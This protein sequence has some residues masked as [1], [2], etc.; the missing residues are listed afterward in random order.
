VTRPTS[1]AFAVFAF[2][3]GACNP[4]L[5]AP[6]L[7]PPPAQ[8]HDTEQSHLLLFPQSDAESLLGRAAQR[9][10]DGTWTIADARAPGCEIS[11]RHEKASFHTSRQVAAHS[12]TS[13][14]GGYAKVVSIEAK[15]GRKNTASIDIDNTEI[16][17]ADTRGACG[18][19]VV[20]TVFVGHGKRSLDA[21]AEAGGHADVKAGLVNASPT[22][23]SG[24]SQSDAL[25][26]RDDQAYG[27]DVR[28]N[29]KVEPLDIRVSMP[30]VVS[31]GDNVEVRFE[32]DRPAWLVVYYIDANQHADVL[33]P[34]NEEPAP[35]VASDAPAVLPSAKERAKDFV[36]KAALLKPGIA[37]RETLVVYGFADKGDFDTLKPSA[38]SENANGPTY[39]A[40]LT[41]KLQY[42]PMNR[43]SRAV[44]GYVI[45]P[46]KM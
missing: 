38:G 8:A 19:L 30:S 21:S 17:R 24:Q 3:F 20:D 2:L 9:S 10:P 23:E 11:V 13:I 4:M 5:P 44:I 25:A 15:F 29:T 1:I 16:L 41:R 28:E 39:A 43:W 37:T 35:R 14:A 27:Y 12:M 32:S 31:E 34:S 22:V 45:Q 6:A 46:K 36:I 7:A 40:E 42:V 18:A 33:W 26:W